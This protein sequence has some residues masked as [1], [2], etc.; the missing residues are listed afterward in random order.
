MYF[1]C[2]VFSIILYFRD[3]LCFFSP[4]LK[5]MLSSLPAHMETAII[6]PEVTSANMEHVVEILEHGVA[7]IS[8]DERKT[9]FDIVEEAQQ[10][11]IFLENVSIY[12]KKM[13]G[14][15]KEGIDN[16]AMSNNQT[17]TSKDL[18]ESEVKES[19]RG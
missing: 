1:I 2:L 14:I 5:T 8:V 13:N 12:K 7:D 4:H 9:Y 19:A 6:I 18:K 3:I 17:C 10:I 15:K 11:G 16:S